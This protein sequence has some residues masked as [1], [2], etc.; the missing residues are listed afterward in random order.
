MSSVPLSG[1]TLAP[2]TLT[3]LPSTIDPVAVW[4]CV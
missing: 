2:L 3:T 1:V 4:T